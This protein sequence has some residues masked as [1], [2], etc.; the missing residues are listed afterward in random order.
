MTLAISDF[1]RS[2]AERNA[3]ARASIDSTAI[4]DDPFITGR[5]VFAPTVL[6]PFGGGGFQIPDSRIP[7]FKGL[8]SSVI[9]SPGLPIPNG[10]DRRQLECG[11]GIW[12]LESRTASQARRE[13]C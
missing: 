4:D 7:N 1:T 3:S 2:Y 12:N 11:I 8:G 10:P 13:A 5:S 6:C 9:W